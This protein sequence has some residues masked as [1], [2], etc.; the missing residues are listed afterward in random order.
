VSHAYEIAAYLF[1]SVLALAMVVFVFFPVQQRE[2]ATEKTRLAYLYERK[3]VIYENLRD[4]NFEY[5]SGKFSPADFEAMRGSMEAEAARV[6]AEIE[7]LETA[8][9]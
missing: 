7:T 2:E 3:D 5:K 9:A 6:L 1:S 4:L 8:K